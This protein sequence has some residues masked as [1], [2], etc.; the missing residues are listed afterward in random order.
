MPP[1]LIQAGCNEVLVDEAT[2]LDG[3]A[4]DAG[5]DVTCELYD[6]R[7][8]IFSMFPFLPNAERALGSVAAF[9]G[10]VRG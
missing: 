1:L 10:R 6:E 3:V 7:L 5:V 9:V 4:K 2:R 8:H